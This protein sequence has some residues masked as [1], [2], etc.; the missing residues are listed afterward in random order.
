MIVKE[1]AESIKIRKLKLI[2]KRFPPHHPVRHEIEVEL[3]KSV[4]G[5]NGEKSLDFHMNLLPDDE[6]FI[7]HDLRLPFGSNH[8]QIDI[9]ILTTTFF[10]IL[11]V[12][13]MAGTLIFDQEF[14]QLIRI[15]N[16]KEDVFSDP[17]SQVYRQTHLLKE[18]LKHHKFPEVPVES[19]VVISNPHTRIKYVPQSI[20]I[21][22]KVTHS[23]NLLAKFH[24]YQHMRKSE[25]ISKKDI[26]KLSRILLKRHS[27]S[28]QDL[29][30]QFSITQDD[31]IKGVACTKC[32]TLS[33]IRSS[34]KWF[35]LKCGHYDKLAHIHALKD[36]ALLNGPAITVHECCDFFQI[37]SRHVVKHLLNAIKLPITPA[38]RHNIYHLENL[39]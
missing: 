1:A 7:F 39:L 38:G 5:Y 4:T 36:F 19:L 12:K 22:Q 11:E 16:D 25:F 6:T 15:S 35:C 32:F 3:L 31:L 21:S 34:R 26:K 17:I 10:L 27:Q 13:N 9:L 37:S 20:K 30:Q 24:D 33:M 23:T 8:F 18:W 29:F 28:N 2:L 14:H